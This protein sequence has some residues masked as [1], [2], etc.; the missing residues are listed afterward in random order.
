M[1]DDCSSDTGSGDE[2][3][4]LEVGPASAKAEYSLYDLLGGS[5]VASITRTYVET[6]RERIQ[7]VADTIKR[8]TTLYELEAIDP[9]VHINTGD[10]EEGLWSQAENE[11][12]KIFGATYRSRSTP[13]RGASIE[14]RE[15]DNVIEDLEYLVEALSSRRAFELEFESF[16]A[17]GMDVDDYFEA[18]SS[19]LNFGS[20]RNT[21]FGAYAN[22]ETTGDAVSASWMSGVFAYSPLERPGSAVLPTRGEATYRGDAVAV[23][24]V[25]QLYSGE[26]ELNAAFST[27]RIDGRVRNLR[28]EDGG[29]WTH[30]SN[31]P[32]EVASIG[33]PRVSFNN[34]AFDTSTSTTT[35]RYTDNSQDAEVGSSA[36]KGEFVNEGSEVLGTWTVGTLLEGSFG[37]TRASSA[38]ATRPTVNDRGAESKVFLANT[39]DP[40][41]SGRITFENGTITIDP[42]NTN[43]A[44][45]DLVAT[46]LHGR[47]RETKPD[48]PESFVRSAR[49]V[50]NNQIAVLN[51]LIADSDTSTGTRD[52]LFQLANQQLDMIFRGAPIVVRELSCR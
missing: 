9:N 5:G 34:G 13:W 14:S 19:R 38:A 4:F 8:Y 20:T 18:P 46:Q 44:Q 10:G 26:I 52:N 43:E 49:T 23:D 12:R 15:V 6:A 27:A 2:G 25:N 28:D 50:I 3:T 48:N 22:K 30:D 35:V 32:K 39:I 36:F 42:S 21:R 24:D 45:I 41:D 37:A 17:E 7:E 40:A 31:D 29:R 51:R 33:L 16:F 47:K 11:L 1:C